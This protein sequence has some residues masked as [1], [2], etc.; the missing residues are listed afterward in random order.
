MYSRYN[1]GQEQQWWKIAKHGCYTAWEPQAAP[2]KSPAFSSVISM[3]IPA[4][5]HGG[6]AA[7]DVDPGPLLLHERCAPSGDSP[8]RL[9]RLGNG[10]LPALSHGWYRHVS[11]TLTPLFLSLSLSIRWGLGHG[12]RHKSDPETSSCTDP[13]R[14]FIRSQTGCMGGFIHVTKRDE[15]EGGGEHGQPGNVGSSVLNGDMVMW[16]N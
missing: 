1:Q 11:E 2:C 13:P 4:E 3:D 14:A 6:A 12:C 9:P 16:L 7:Q 5:Q 10:A 8:P 15:E